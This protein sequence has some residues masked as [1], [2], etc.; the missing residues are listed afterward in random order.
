MIA[1][2]ALSTLIP[3]KIVSPKNLTSAG[4]AK[5]I[6]NVV[7]LY[8]ALPQGPAPVR[9]ATGMIGKYRAKYFDG[10]NASGKPIVHFAIFV[11]CLGYS[12]DYYFHLRHHKGEGH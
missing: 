6:A 2:R 5:R 11:L 1:K 4:S 3:P 12:M 7:E 9:Q 8:K 10:D